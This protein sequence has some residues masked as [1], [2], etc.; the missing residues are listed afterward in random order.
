M[1]AGLRDL[2]WVGLSRGAASRNA[3]GLGRRRRDRCK[4]TRVLVPGKTKDVEHGSEDPPR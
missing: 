1:V 2:E 3:A 4:S